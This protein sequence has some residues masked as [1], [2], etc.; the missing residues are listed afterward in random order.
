MGSKQANLLVKLSHLYLE[1]K[2]QVS[3]FEMLVKSL[4]CTV[5]LWKVQCVKAEPSDM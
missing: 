1:V 3:T 4:N 2:P 5:K